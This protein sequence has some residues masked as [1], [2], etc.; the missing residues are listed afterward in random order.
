[1]KLEPAMEDWLL[2]ATAWWLA[3]FGP[4]ERPHLVLPVGDHFPGEQPD[5]L[6]EAVQ[7]HA[8]MSRAEGWRFELVDETDGVAIPDPLA[9]LPRPA[10]PV[11]ARAPVVEEAEEDGPAPSGPL[12]IPYTAAHRADPAGFIRLLALGVS[13]YLLA[14]ARDEVPGGESAREAFVELGAVQLGFGVFLSNGCFRFQQHEDGLMVGASWSHAGDLGEDALGYATA[15]FVELHG[16][17]EREA[18]RHL[19][20]NPRAAFKWALKQLRGPRR[21]ELDRLRA[22][23]RRPEGAGPYR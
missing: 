13:H 16:A 17:G 6:L 10:S 23:Q 12:P 2:S 22:I 7:E 14:G 15:L 21:A 18:L 4:P 9:N 1:M 3:E 19:G 20:A 5:D 8:E 11:A